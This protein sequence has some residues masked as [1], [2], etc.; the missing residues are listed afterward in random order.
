MKIIFKTKAEVLREVESDDL[1]DELQDELTDHFNDMEIEEYSLTFK[2]GIK[3]I[4]VHH[5]DNINT[6]MLQAITIT[7]NPEIL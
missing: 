7:V 4:T 5:L 3:V 6:G 2:P 1:S